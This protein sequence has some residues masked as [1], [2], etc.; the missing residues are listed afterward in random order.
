MC[1]H[2]GNFYT[3][4]NILFFGI[5]YLLHKGNVV[6]LPSNGL[7]FIWRQYRAGFWSRGLWIQVDRGISF[8][9]T[10]YKP[11]DFREFT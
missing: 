4:W 2:L 5:A 7:D 9:S 6:I 8:G 1:I 3:S 11:Y 10:T